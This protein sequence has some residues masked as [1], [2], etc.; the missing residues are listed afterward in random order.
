MLKIGDLVI[1]RYDL[2]SDQH[3]KFIVIDVQETSSCY[4]PPEFHLK[5]F[6]L[7]NSRVNWLGTYTEFDMDMFFTKI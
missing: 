1:G 3:M 2:N 4:D 5:A 7:W 6:T